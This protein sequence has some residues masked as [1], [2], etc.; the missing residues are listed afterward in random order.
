M[1]AA[2]RGP[3]LSPVSPMYTQLDACCAPPHGPIDA[4][5]QS[6]FEAPETRHMPRLAPV[7][8]IANSTPVWRRLIAAAEFS[9]RA[10][11]PR[12]GTDTIFWS[13]A[14]C[15]SAKAFGDAR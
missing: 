4:A 5:S 10:R 8:S 12:T 15:D 11:T 1:A 3:E 7:V 13:D 2:P 9:T 6:M 14:P